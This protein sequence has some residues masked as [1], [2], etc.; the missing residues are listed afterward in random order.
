LIEDIGVI[1]KGPV[2]IGDP[3]KNDLQCN[4]QGAPNK[5][6]VKKF[7]EFDPYKFFQR[8]FGKAAA[9]KNP[10]KNKKQGHTETVKNHIGIDKTLG[11]CNVSPFNSNQYMPVNNKDD[12]NAPQV[13]YPLESAFVYH[14]K[15]K[16]F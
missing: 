12:G 10:R 2:G 8:F 11:H 14:R 5:V 3:G 16:A 6:R 1:N 15:V 7:F 4:L 9:D 13:V